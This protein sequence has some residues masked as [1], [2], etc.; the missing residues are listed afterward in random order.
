MSVHI[1][2]L[3]ITVAVTL[4]FGAAVATYWRPPPRPAVPAPAA[5]EGLKVQLIRC[6][7]GAHETEALIKVRLRLRN[8]G[9]LPARI[10]PG[11]FW[12]LDAEGMPYLDRH[13]AEKPDEPPLKLAPGQTGPEMELT[14]ALAPHVLARPLMLLIG[15]A[16]SGKAAGSP[17]PRQGIRVPLKDA[18]APKG[19]FVEGEWKTFTGSHWQ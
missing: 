5:L 2:V 3:T 13:A 15:E 8:D 14:F 19:P 6:D 1:R 17:P 4:I 16:P 11:S 12:L 9:S 7:L 18:G 10:G